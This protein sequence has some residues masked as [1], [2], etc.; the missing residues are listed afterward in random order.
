MLNKLTFHNYR[1]FSIKH[2]GPYFFKHHRG[3]LNGD[4]G[5]CNQ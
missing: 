1:N 3:G 4:K 5:A 2:L